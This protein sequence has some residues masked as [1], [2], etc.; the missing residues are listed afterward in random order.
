LS[1]RRTWLNDSLPRD[2]KL[3][4]RPL[5]LDAELR[6]KPLWN[7]IAAAFAAAPARG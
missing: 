5:P 6:R 7:A 4:Q 1:D 2:D 3:A